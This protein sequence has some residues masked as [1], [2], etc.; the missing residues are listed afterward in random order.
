MSRLAALAATALIVSLAPFAFG[1]IVS[2]TVKTKLK[3]Y[4][5]LTLFLM[6][7][8]G[9]RADGVLCLSLLA[10]SPEEVRAQFPKCR[11]RRYNMSEIVNA[12]ISAGFTLRRLDEHP[13][14][15]NPALPG[16]FTVL[17]TRTEE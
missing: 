7:P 11:Y 14:W 8:Q 12:I 9:G 15:E 16:E 3:N 2:H 17:A 13:A 4:E 5:Q 10:K 6:M 1:D